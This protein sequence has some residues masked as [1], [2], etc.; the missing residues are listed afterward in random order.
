M[1]YRIDFQRNNTR[2]GKK[3]NN[4]FRLSEDSF[5]KFIKNVHF[6]CWD[7][8]FDEPFPKIKNEV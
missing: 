1:D 3:V 4:I 8:F 5:I 6:S 2:E 7:N